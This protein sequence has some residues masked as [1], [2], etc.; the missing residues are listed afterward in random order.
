M[1]VSVLWA[2][3]SHTGAWTRERI[4]PTGT[5]HLSLRTCGT[6]IRLGPGGEQVE[7]RVIGGPRSVAHIHDT[8]AARSV[9]VVFAPGALPAL[10]GESARALAE[11]HT[12]L[13]ALWGADAERLADQLAD[14]DDDTALDRLEAMLVR[15]LRPIATPAGVPEALAALARGARVDEVARALGRSPRTL[16]IWFDDLVG[17]SPRRWASLQR[18][19]RALALAETEPDGSV[20]AHMAGYCDQAH[21]CRDVRAMVGATLTECRQHVPGERNHIPI[22]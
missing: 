22:R 15:H 13:D 19:R 5:A 17:V 10:F 3:A 7:T 2:G 18:L 8:V 12:S 21:L 1:L 14:A 6:P 4:V 20:V 9:G 16:G 11:Q